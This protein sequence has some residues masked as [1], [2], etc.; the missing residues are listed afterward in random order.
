MFRIFP[1]RHFWRLLLIIGLIAADLSAQ[2]IHEEHAISSHP[3]LNSIEEAALLGVITGEN[4]ILQKIYAG[5]TPERL[6]S[7]FLKD[8]DTPIRCMVPVLTEYYHTKTILDPA[9]VAEIEEIIQPRTTLSTKA[10]IS[11]SGRFVL[12][13]DVDGNNAVPMDDLNGSGVPDYVEHAAFAADS[14]YRYQVEQLGFVDFLKE[15]PYEVFF[16]NF[17][18]YGT[19]TASGSTTSIT[20]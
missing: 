20:V 10:H 5:Y 15:E 9:I 11:D 7:R 8:N 1:E 3:V 12:Y 19:T 6:D 16:R 18:F 13:Y 2:H 14:S 17:R 4:A